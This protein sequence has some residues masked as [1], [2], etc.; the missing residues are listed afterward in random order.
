MCYPLIFMAA[1]AGISAIAAVKQGQDRKEEADAQATQK[2]IES[3]YAA[4]DAR[5]RAEKIRKLGRAQKGEA[6]AALAASGVQLGE[7]TPL[8]ISKTIAQRSEED[9]LSAI[10]GGTRAKR[11]LDTE[12]GLLRSAGRNAQSSANLSAASSALGAYGSYSKG[13]WVTAAKG[14]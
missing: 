11:T 3:A 13:G 7:G 4:D 10:L 2:N 12:A 6:T 1:A 9:A 14:G 5:A 8:E